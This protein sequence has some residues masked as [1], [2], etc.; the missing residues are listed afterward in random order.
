[1][2]LKLKKLQDRWYAKL[3]K[4]GFD[5]IEQRDGNLKTWHSSMF[6]NRRKKRYTED[7]W[8]SKIEYYRLAEH[9]LNDNKFK[10]EQEKKTWELHSEGISY[11]KISIRLKAL[12]FKR[13]V[14]KDSIHKLIKLL[15]ATMVKVCSTNET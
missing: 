9:F 13:G 2:D 1:M 14:S 5:D 4:E 8:D 10:N 6:Q 3:K 15:A 7:S 12:G 11:E